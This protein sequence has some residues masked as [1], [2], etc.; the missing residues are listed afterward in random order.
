MTDAN[1][2]TINRNNIAWKDDQKVRYNNIDVQAQR[3]SGLISDEYLKMF[4]F[5]KIDPDTKQ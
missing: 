5:Y 1:R 2:I 3:R 4:T